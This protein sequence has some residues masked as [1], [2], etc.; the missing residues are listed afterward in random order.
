[1][2]SNEDLERFYLSTK[3][4]LYLIV[5]PFSYFVYTIMCLTIYFQNGIGIPVAN[6]PL[7]LP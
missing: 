2:Y 4:W 3:Q 5:N 1:M 6:D 7:V